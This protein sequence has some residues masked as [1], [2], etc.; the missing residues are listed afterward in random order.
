MT[1]RQYFAELRTRVADNADLVAFIDHEVE[2]L[3]KK[4]SAPKG[5]TKKQIVND[6]LK[7][8]IMNVLGT[9][10]M[11]ATAIRDAFFPDLTVQKISALLAQLVADNALTKTVEKRVSYFAKVA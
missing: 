11:T 1:K 3:D 2:L 7:G 9:D 5:P 6:G 4:N 10:P 8:D